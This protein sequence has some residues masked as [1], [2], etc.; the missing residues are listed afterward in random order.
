MEGF[1]ARP[2]GG[3]LAKYAIPSELQSSIP[4]KPEKPE[5]KMLPANKDSTMAEKAADSGGRR[6]TRV[7][8]RPAIVR[9]PPAK[10]A[11]PAQPRT[12]TSWMN[13]LSIP[14]I[15][16]PVTLAAR[17]SD[18]SPVPSGRPTSPVM[19]MSRRAVLSL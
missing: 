19:A 2:P 18:P 7:M 5:P 6:L 16:T 17:P 9:N 8:A 14:T 10:S 11:A 1:P 4:A 12:Y 15:P 13:P 3:K